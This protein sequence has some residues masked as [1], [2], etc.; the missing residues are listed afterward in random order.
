MNDRPSTV[1]TTIAGLA[2]LN[3]MN[4]PAA[5]EVMTSCCGSTRWAERMISARPY[6]SAGSLLSESDRVW[7]GLERAD[8]LE[9]FA[10]HPRIGERNLTQP[11]FAATAAQAGREQSGMA[12]ATEAQHAEF[13]AR[14]MS[15]MSRSSGTSF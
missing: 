7:F 1:A 15:G 10:H 4:A 2:R 12:L 9:A 6:A 5:A 8:W 11:K 3:A 13:G 14:A